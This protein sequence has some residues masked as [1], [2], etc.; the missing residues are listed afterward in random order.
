MYKTNNNEINDRLTFQRID[1]LTLSYCCVRRG[2][3]RRSI[4]EDDLRKL[5]H[6]LLLIAQD[7]ESTADNQS[8]R[9]RL[10]QWVG[11]TRHRVRS[12]R[13]ML[14]IRLSRP[15]FA[16]MSRSLHVRVMINRIAVIGRSSLDFRDCISVAVMFTEHN[17]PWR[18]S[19]GGADRLSC[20]R[21]IISRQGKIGRA[22]SA[23]C[24]NLMNCGAQLV[25]L[26][27]T[28]DIR[29]SLLPVLLVGLSTSSAPCRMTSKRGTGA[30]FAGKP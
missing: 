8:D 1:F 24:W 22:G 5:R 19:P 4:T 10:L 29:T 26:D 25:H 15:C 20:A 9:I 30:G 7:A 28:C 18:L 11:A 13:A 14:I 23:C 6:L 21:A 27:T 3:K 17:S 2:R 12:M 16:Q